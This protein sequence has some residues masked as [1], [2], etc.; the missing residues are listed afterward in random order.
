MFLQIKSIWSRLARCL[1]NILVWKIKLYIQSSSSEE[2]EY[3]AVLHHGVSRILILKTMIFPWNFQDSMN[4]SQISES[5][6]LWHLQDFS[7]HQQRSVMLYLWVLLCS[8]NST[9]LYIQIF[10]THKN[11]KF[12]DTWMYPEAYRHIPYLCKKSKRKKKLRP[13]FSYTF[14]FQFFRKCDWGSSIPAG[15]FLRKNLFNFGAVTVYIA[16]I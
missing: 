1:M 16:Y 13:Q 10:N 3:A 11:S 12:I 15:K 7:W 2:W 5:S 14:N 8:V 4:G 6:V 9:W